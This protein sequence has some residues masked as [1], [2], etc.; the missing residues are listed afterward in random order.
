MAA[1]SDQDLVDVGGLKSRARDRG[2]RGNRAEFGWMGVAQR[3]AVTA[4]GRASGRQDDDIG[5][6]AAVYREGASVASPE[7]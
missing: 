4:D 3:A 1:V 5:H 2:P 6:R 7:A